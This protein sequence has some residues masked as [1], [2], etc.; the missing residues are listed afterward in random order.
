M[1]ESQHLYTITCRHV[2]N[3]IICNF[4]DYCLLKGDYIFTLQ[5][6]RLVRMTFQSYPGYCYKCIPVPS[7]A[8]LVLRFIT[9]VTFQST[10]S[11]YSSIYLL[12]N[13][14][15]GSPTTKHIS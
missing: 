3:L 6:Y 14:L 2:Y 1:T 4:I 15:D 10:G 9:A 13:L 12:D 8:G 7:R 11:I 5:L